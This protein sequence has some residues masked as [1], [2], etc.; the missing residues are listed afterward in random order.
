MVEIKGS[1][2]WSNVRYAKLL[3]NIRKTLEEICKI[4]NTNV[5]FVSK[6]IE[7]ANLCPN[8]PIKIK[9]S[10]SNKNAIGVSICT[11]T[12]NQACVG[13]LIFEKE[14]SEETLLKAIKIVF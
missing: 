14:I 11:G 2:M 1:K 12:K 13:F 9:K 5:K 10:A 4:L 3:S 8:N 6:K 7:T